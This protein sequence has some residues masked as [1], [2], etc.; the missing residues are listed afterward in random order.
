M[1]RFSRKF[2]YYLS[3]IIPRRVVLLLLLGP[4]NNSTLFYKRHVRNLTGVQHTQYLCGQVIRL[5]E[6]ESRA[7][8]CFSNIQATSISRSYSRKCQPVAYYHVIYA[9]ADRFRIIG[10]Q[11]WLASSLLVSV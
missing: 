2:F 1:L 11:Y 8:L 5:V 7:C 9:I 4:S 10:K 6:I 3:P